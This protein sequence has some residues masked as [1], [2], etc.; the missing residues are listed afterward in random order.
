[1]LL[2]KL[3]VCIGM[4][5]QR[6]ILEFYYYK[7][8]SSVSISIDGIN[9]QRHADLYTLPCVII[10]NASIY[11]KPRTQTQTRTGQGQQEDFFL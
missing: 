9:M 7:N 5:T 4:S 11:W 3:A 2:L 6:K 1:M 10:R 8:Y